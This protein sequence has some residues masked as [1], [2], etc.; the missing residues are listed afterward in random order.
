MRLKFTQN[1][2][3]KIILKKQASIMYLNLDNVG[4]IIV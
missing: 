3:Q 4:F 2:K 1:L